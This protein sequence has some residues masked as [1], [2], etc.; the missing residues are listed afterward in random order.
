MNAKGKKDERARRE[1]REAKKQHEQHLSHNFTF[2]F[3]VEIPISLRAS[4]FAVPCARMQRQNHKDAFDFD[5][6][7]HLN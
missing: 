4:A 3:R 2:T 6:I 7:L 5:T 1:F